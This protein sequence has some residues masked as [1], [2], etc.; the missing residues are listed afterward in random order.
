MTSSVVL[1]FL[2]QVSLSLSLDS[3]SLLTSSQ[4]SVITPDGQANSGH[5][6]LAS[7]NFSLVVQQQSE[8][9]NPMDDRLLMPVT[10]NRTWVVPDN[11]SARGVCGEQSSEIDLTWR[12]QATGEENLLKLVITRKGRLAGLTGVFMW[13]SHEGGKLEMSV[14]MDFQD[15]ITLAWPIRYGLSCPRSLQF[16][17]YP[18]PISLPM[19][20]TIGT[21]KDEK[22]TPLAFLVVKNLQLEAFR[23][24]TLLDQ[25]PESMSQDFYRR[26]WECEFHMTF[27]WAPI[28][29]GGGLGCL[30]GF[31]LGAFLCKSNI[32][33][34]DG[35]QSKYDKF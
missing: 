22:P 35:R 34:G 11:A 6:L 18:A 15:F 10:V 3:Q 1:L 16:P 25:Y 5:C 28:A 9:D 27:D 23:G 12:D 19:T 30:V 17:L 31:M 26:R 7:G 2:S 20:S 4:W 14:E 24:E 33:C 8:A 21:S 29:V 13:M 32:G